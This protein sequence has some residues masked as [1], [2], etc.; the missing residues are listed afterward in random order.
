M[1][2][3]KFLGKEIVIDLKGKEGEGVCNLTL[4]NKDIYSMCN[5]GRKLLT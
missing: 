1:K 5:S 3:V 4:K 2:L